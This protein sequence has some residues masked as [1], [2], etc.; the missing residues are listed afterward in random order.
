MLFNIIKNLKK[1]VSN[2]DMET[3]KASKKILLDYPEN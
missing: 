1:A 2:D 3:I